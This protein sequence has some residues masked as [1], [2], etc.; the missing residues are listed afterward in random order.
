MGKILLDK[1]GVTEKTDSKAVKKVN[2][3]PYFPNEADFNLFKSEL[4]RLE[5]DPVQVDLFLKTYGLEQVEGLKDYI[6]NNDI[7]KDKVNELLPTQN[8]KNIASQAH[9]YT[10]VQ[11]AIEAYNKSLSV[12]S[13][14]TTAAT[15]STK[16]FIDILSTNNT[17]LADCMR[18]ANGCSIKISDYA[19]SLGKSAIKTVALTRPDNRK[20][21]RFITK[22]LR[23][24][25]GTE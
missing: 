20:E 14:K 2:I 25:S 16:K 24:V 17:K 3:I 15:D 4:D 12:N 1:F 6:L 22:R 9:G 5:K 19:V 10:G 7:Q 23:T 11:K 21:Y 8:F 18:N 13:D